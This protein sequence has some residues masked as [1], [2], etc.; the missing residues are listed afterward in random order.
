LVRN[1]SVSEGSCQY[2][3]WKWDQG[4]RA[5]DAEIDPIQGHVDL[6]KAL[7]HV[8]MIEPYDPDVNE[9]QRVR[10]VGR[11]L[12]EK[13]F[14]Q[15]AWRR[16]RTMYLKDE[17]GDNDRERPIA[18]GFQARGPGKIGLACVLQLSSRALCDRRDCVGRSVRRLTRKVWALHHA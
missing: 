2:S 7:E 5:E 12:F 18:E 8:L 4:R 17:E 1:G 15:L 11:P 3:R 6:A 10:D 16:T 9:S 13:F 14:R